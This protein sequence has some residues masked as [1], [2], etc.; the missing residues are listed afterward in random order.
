MLQ[1]LKRL[2]NFK[3]LDESSC[4][5]ENPS[6]PSRNINFWF[7]STHIFKAMRNQLMASSQG[8]KKAFQDKN[9]VEF[10][11]AYLVKLL[12]ILEDEKNQCDN[13]VSFGCRL[14]EKVISPKGQ[15]AMNVSLAKQA[16]ERG[17]LEYA[18]SNMY[19]KLDITEEYVQKELA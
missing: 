11:W 16:M 15:L 19:K 5:T 9:D 14:S 10:E 12:G 4:K 17:T 7:C 2:Q 6:K 13:R 8:G 1:D 18:I 3:W